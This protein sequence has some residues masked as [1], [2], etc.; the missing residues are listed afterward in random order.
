MKKQFLPFLALF[1]AV[2][3]LVSSCDKNED[4]APKTKTELITQS[5][6]KVTSATVNGSPYTLNACIL[7]NIYIFSTGGTG[8]M[9]ESAN[10]CA[11]AAAGVTPFT[12]SFQAGETSV[13][14]STPLFNGGFNTVTLVSLSETQLVVSFPYSPGPGVNL[15]I[16]VTFQH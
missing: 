15:T 11:G 13:Q 6:W 4:P 16:V 2:S 7:D 5:S 1:T 9:N 12:W 8:S 14:L 3:F 10:V